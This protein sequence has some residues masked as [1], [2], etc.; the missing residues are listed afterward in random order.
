MA[1]AKSFTWTPDTPKGFLNEELDNLWD[2]INALPSGSYVDLSTT[3]TVGGTKTWTDPQVWTSGTLHM[4]SSA[5][6]GFKF[7][8]QDGTGRFAFYWNTLGGT[9]PTYLVGDPEHAMKMNFAPN[10]TDSYAVQYASATGKNAGD[11]IT[12][13]TMFKVSNVGDMTIGRKIADY[14]GASVT[15]HSTGTTGTLTPNMN[16]G[17]HMKIGTLTGNITIANPSN[18]LDDTPFYI[19]IKPHASTT[20]TVSWGT[21]YYFPNGVAPTSM[22]GGGG[23]TVVSCM[24]YDSTEVHCTAAENLTTL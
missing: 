2:A 24:Y 15:R 23:F 10:I 7:R 11:A 20:Y 3:Q 6:Q 18:F 9:S 14:R 17:T 16:S 22:T 21:Y 1:T 5:I 12:W 13:F 8:R 4:G 19:T